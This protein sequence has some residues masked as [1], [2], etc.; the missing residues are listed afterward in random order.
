V[1]R[2]LIALFCLSLFSV[3]YVA[4][5]QWREQKKHYLKKETYVKYLKKEVFLSKLNQSLPKWM[6]EQLQEDFRE[7]EEKGIAKTQIDATFAQIQEAFPTPFIVRYRI[8]ENE[9]YRYFRQGELIS[10]EDTST[11]LAFKT[12]LQCVSIPDIDFIVSFFDGIR[13]SHTFF[14]PPTKDLQAPLLISAKIKNTPYAVL[15]PDFRSIGHWWISDIK[16]VKSKM[17]LIPWEK[18]KEFAIWR[19]AN[20]REER[21]KLCRLSLLFPL[22]LDARFIPPIN[23]R[24]LETEGLMGERIDWEDF[25]ECKYLPYVDG[26]MTAAPALQWRLLSNS[27]TFKPETDEIQWF[28][29]ALEPNV[30]YVPLKTDLSDLI[31]K[32]AWAK[33]HDAQCKQIAYESTQF[34]LHNLM[35]EDV[36]LYFNAVLN[37]YA[38]LQKI[39]FREIREEVAANPHWVKIQYRNVLRKKANENQMAGYDPHSTPGTSIISTSLT[40]VTP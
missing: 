11:E 35:Y 27:V 16:H 24:Q 23:R 8:L 1:K 12:L 28:N 15:I 9:L 13:P 18:K 40:S 37:R 39:D 4:W 19:G 5:G 22:Y 38:S 29:R 34:A 6:Q 3:S 7:F 30:H 25:L 31:E 20:N 32:L 36:L 2:Y 33:L 26:Y 14:H 10:L 21:I 17:D